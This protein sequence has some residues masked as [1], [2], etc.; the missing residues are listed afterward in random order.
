LT[1][2]PGNEKAAVPLLEPSRTGAPRGYLSHG[3]GEN[4]VARYRR[5]Q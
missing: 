4:R 5:T 3:R 1:A 2:L